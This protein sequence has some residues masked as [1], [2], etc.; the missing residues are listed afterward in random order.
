VTL[1]LGAGQFLNAATLANKTGAAPSIPNVLGDNSG[2]SI[3]DI[4]KSDIMNVGGFGLSSAA[5]KLNEQIMNNSY[6]SQLLSLGAGTDATAEG[7]A[8]MIKGL[9]ASLPQSMIR[10]DLRTEQ[11]D[12]DTTVP[13][14]E[15]G[16]I[17]DEEA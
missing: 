11:E 14:S 5:R 6:A 4:A 9:R 17:V 10:E 15:N 7:S 1:I 2:A 8:T 13:A 12:S 3:L 16:Q